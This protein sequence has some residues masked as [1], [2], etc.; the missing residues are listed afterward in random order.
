M[1]ISKETIKVLNNFAKYNK[2]LI[3][4]PGSTLT[5]TTVTETIYIKCE[6]SEYFP[7]VASFFDIKKFLSCIESLTNPNIEFNNDSLIISNKV[8]DTDKSINITYYY[9]SPMTIVTPR[10]DVVFNY[11]NCLLKFTLNQNDLK[12]IKRFS[13]DLSLKRIKFTKDGLTLFDYK[14]DNT[15]EFRNFVDIG[16]NYDLYNMNEN[17]DIILSTDNL[18]FIAGT[19]SVS[20]CETM[21]SF[22]MI[23]SEEIPYNIEYII[24]NIKTKKNSNK[25]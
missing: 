3:I 21:T 14:N 11:N 4:N 6:V 12:N 2:G 18:E 8:S 19:Y 17:N 10:K 13:N 24:A 7:V 16:I 23:S 5:T 1:I 15:S 20:I 22:K 9:S 25:S